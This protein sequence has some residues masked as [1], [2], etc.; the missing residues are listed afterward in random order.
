M[1]TLDHSDLSV[2]GSLANGLMKEGRGSRS[3]PV[4]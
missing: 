3:S 4:E 1:T 2:V